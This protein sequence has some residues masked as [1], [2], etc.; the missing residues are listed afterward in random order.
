MIMMVYLGNRSDHAA[1]WVRL[2][3][4][5]PWPSPIGPSRGMKPFFVALFIVLLL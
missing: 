2:F 5:A 1:R 4:A 3:V